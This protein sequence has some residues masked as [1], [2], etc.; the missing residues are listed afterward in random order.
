MSDDFRQ[1]DH[2]LTAADYVVRV[3]GLLV[4]AVLVSVLYRLLG[5]E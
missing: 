5:G 2:Q 1:V 4:V 3:M